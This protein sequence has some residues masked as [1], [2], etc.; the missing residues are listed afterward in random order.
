[1]NKNIKRLLSALLLIVSV[2]AFAQDKGKNKLR[3]MSYNVHNGVGIDNVTSYQR[4]ADLFNE[5]KPDVVALQELDSVTIRSEGAD[6]LKEIAVKSAMYHTFG[7][8]IDL[9]GGQYGVGILSKEI[10]LFTE[11]IPLP[12]TE[13]KRTALFAEFEDFWVCCTHFSL[14]EQDRLASVEII[15]DYVKNID[16]P[17]FLVGDINALPG[18]NVLINLQNNFSL[19]N[20]TTKGTYPSTTPQKCIDYICGYMGNG[21]NYTV[22]KKEV[23]EL[24]ASDHAPLYAD[25][26]IHAKEDEIFRTTPFLQ[27][28][29]DGKVSISW[30][31]NVPVHAW[32]EFGSTK[33]LETKITP[34]IG[35]QAIANNKHHKVLIEDL[36]PG[37]T[38]YY[39][40]VSR[41]ITHYGAYKKEF[42]N[43]AYS[44]IYSFTVPGK[45]SDF[46]AVIFND[47]HKRKKL[48]D[49]LMEIIDDIPYDLAF[50]NGDCI[51]DPRNEADALDYLSYIN[52][53][54]GASSIPVFFIRGNHEIRDAWSVE[55]N[56][57]I[58]YVGGKTYGAFTWVDTRFVMLD[59]GEDK[60][61]STWVYYGLNEFEEF[62]KEQAVFLETEIKSEE[63]KKAKKRILLHHIP[64]YAREQVRYNPGNDLWHPLLQAAPFEVALNGHTHRYAFLPKGVQANNFPVVVGG[65]DKVENAT[66]IIINKK[67]DSMNLKAIKATGEVLIDLEL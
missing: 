28:M 62:R 4:I 26:V 31:T 14:A 21:N 63:F 23:I 50:F 29:V 44:D 51:D 55:L 49:K 65:G 66:V 36:T 11:N 67:D 61:D 12:G 34:L 17:L 1:M 59:C 7:G 43:T 41:E 60:P 2:S 52:D 27:N 46:T 8:A 18:S 10:P 13:E 30:F 64:I 54:V 38:Y 53:K 45:N 56:N 33:E 39:R 3:I 19:L 5:Y 20:D 16:K 35:G 6:V 37:K 25:V 40:V 48:L 32:V 15:A 57:V 22:L 42:G 47:L 58:D 24:Q 9:Q